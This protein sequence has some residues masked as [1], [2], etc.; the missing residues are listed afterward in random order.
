MK[1]SLRERIR[2]LLGAAKG[3][4]GRGGRRHFP[5]AATARARHFVDRIVS[6]A[7]L[8]NETA[9]VPDRAARRA[10]FLAAKL[11]EFGY[12]DPR[13]DEQGGISVT[14]PGS[15]GADAAVLVFADAG[16]PADAGAECIVTLGADRAEGRGLAEDSV[17]VAALLVLAEHLAAAEPPFARDLV[18][19]F[20]PGDGDQAVQWP[21]RG[22][23]L[24]LERFIR[25]SGSG[26]ALAVHLRSIALGRIEERPLGACRLRVQVRTEEKDV[27]T[28][29]GGASAISILA[30]IAS[31]LGSIRWDSEGST[32]LNIARLEAG[33]GFGW[34]AS[35]GVLELEIMSTEAAAL[36]V[37]RKAV[38]ATIQTTAAEPG[39]SVEVA[40]ASLYPPGRVEINAGLTAALR[41]VYARLRIRAASVSIP[42]Q[43]A[44]ASA[45]G[46]PAVSLGITTGRKTLTEEW[47]DIPPIETGFRQVLAFLEETTR[48]GQG[49]G[50]GG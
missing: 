18:L 24:P 14:V 32:F 33:A 43:S 45:L 29:A 17:G 42:D 36:E 7:I 2:Q 35:E 1:K 48:T 20:L 38:T 4:W 49:E 15:A 21:A 50:R 26:F 30:A 37:A 16:F 9:Y 12:P 19:Y 27:A 41:R 22:G 11:R 47:V 44:V 5:R 3:I 46:I 25:G 10:D 28:A 39:A 13:V 40:T 31:R 8:F 23:E 6:D 34:H